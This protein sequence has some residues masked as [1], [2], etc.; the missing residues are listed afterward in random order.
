[1]KFKD[2]SERKIFALQC[3]RMH[4]DGYY[5]NKSEEELQKR[6]EPIRRCVADELARR[7]GEPIPVFV[8]MVQERNN[9]VSQ[10]TTSAS[11]S[12]IERAAAPYNI[13]TAALSTLGLEKLF[14][15]HYKD[16]SNRIN[17]KTLMK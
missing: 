15:A 6:L 4:T 13:N 3:R 1:M 16:D 14:P 5:S 12:N 2:G 9:M 8:Q 10:V 11:A 17:I 7:I